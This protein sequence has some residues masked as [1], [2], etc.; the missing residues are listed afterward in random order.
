MCANANHEFQLNVYDIIDLLLLFKWSPLQYTWTLGEL[1]TSSIAVITIMP[2]MGLALSQFTLTQRLPEPIVF[3]WNEIICILSSTSQCERRRKPM[4]H[5][6]PGC[7]ANNENKIIIGDRASTGFFL[8]KTYFPVRRKA[9]VVGTWL[10][11]WCDIK[12][13]YSSRIWMNTIYKS[14]DQLAEP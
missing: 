14:I 4:M 5:T 7:V 9:I 10:W 3:C 13:N 2:S 11:R 1:C 8:A 6:M 12:T